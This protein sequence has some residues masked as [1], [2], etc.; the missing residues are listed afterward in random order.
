MN[1]TCERPPSSDGTVPLIE[2]LLSGNVDAMAQP[3]IWVGTK[4]LDPGL[5]LPHPIAHGIPSPPTRDRP[6]PLLTRRRRTNVKST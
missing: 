1:K 2:L 5:L 6:P 4:P 3:E